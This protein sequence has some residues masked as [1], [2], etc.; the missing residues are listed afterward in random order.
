MS[1]K[2]TLYSRFSIA[3]P[4]IIALET[5]IIANDKLRKM[6]LINNNGTGRSSTPF[7]CRNSISHTH[8]YT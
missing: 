8:T 2:R 7:A 4:S 5:F 1:Q 6:S 3:T